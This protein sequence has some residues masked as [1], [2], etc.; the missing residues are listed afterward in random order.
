MSTVSQVETAI[1]PP[2]IAS[3]PSPAARNVIISANPRA[4]SRSRHANI[5]S[6]VGVLTNAGYTVQLL[7]SLDELSGL[8]ASQAKTGG[9]RA[10]VAIGGDGTASIVRTHVPLEV[11]LL[12]V[13]MG[14]ENLLG[15]FVS[16]ATDPIAVC[17]TLDEGV[18]VGLDLGRANGKLFLLMISAGFDAEVVRSLH[19]NRRGN[20]TRAAYF[21]PMVRAIRSYQYPQMQLYCGDKP[22][23]PASLQ[24]RWLFAFNLPLYALGLPIAPDALATDGLLDVCT[25][26]RGSTWSVLRYLWHVR[27]GCHLGLPDTTLR[28]CSSFRLEGPN[29][30]ELA[31]QVDGE[32]GGLLPVDVELLPGELRLLVTPETAA[33]LGFEIR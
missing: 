1:L 7:T 25:F 4:G 22:A 33:R 3:R 32:Y 26:E 23:P 18:T 12:P 14:T 29:S 21:L 16:Q 28:R 8:S 11:P 6:I 17:R 2:Q 30:L 19:M 20:I 15:R 10:V 27:R 31:Y 9:L 13:P 5:E 24:C